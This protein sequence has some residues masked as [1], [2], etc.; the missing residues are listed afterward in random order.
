MGRSQSLPT[1]TPH[2]THHTMNAQDKHSRQPL[3]V[4]SIENGMK[5]TA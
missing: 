2:R 5:D 1:T 4:V 3:T